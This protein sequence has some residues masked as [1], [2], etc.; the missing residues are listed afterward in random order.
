MNGLIDR[1]RRIF[2]VIII[3]F[4][5]AVVARSYPVL[6]LE[7]CLT[8]GTVFITTLLLILWQ[9]LTQKRGFAIDSPNSPTKSHAIHTKSTPTSGGIVIFLSYWV[10]LSFLIVRKDFIFYKH[11]FVIFLLMGSTLAIVGFIDDLIH[12]RARYKLF[13]ELILGALIYFVLRIE[14]FDFGI[15]RIHS[16]FIA[17]VLFEFFFV[18][19]INSINFIDGIDGLAGGVSIIIL[20]VIAVLS[21]KMGSIPQYFLS[22]YLIIVLGNFMIFNFPPALIFMGDSG[23]MF[24]GGVIG[25]LSLFSGTQKL[26]FHIYPFILVL[27]IPMLDVSWAII[28]RLK[29]NRNIFFPDKQ[30]LHHKLLRKGFSLLQTVMLLWMMTGLLA[31]TAVITFHSPTYIKL[32]VYISLLIIWFVT[33]KIMH[34]I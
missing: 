15:F 17:L 12:V 19:V 22:V 2:A 33:G 5:L 30:H 14:I 11:E 7:V 20:I 18:G 9:C 29:N 4:L 27:F 6:K 23:S 25:Y 32:L 1:S 24:I 28:R 10:V 13:I 31:L 3:A 16:G 21:L 26:T 34:W 8:L